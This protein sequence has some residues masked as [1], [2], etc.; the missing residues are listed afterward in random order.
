MKV[1]FITRSTLQTVPGGDTIQIVQT[2]RHLRMLGVEADILSA[3]AAIPYAQ[4]DLLHL[5]NITRPAD[6]LIHAQRCNIPYVI[7]PILIDYSEYDRHYRKGF[8][9]WLLRTG[10]PSFNEY[11]KTTARWLL[12][13]DKLVS[14]TYLWKGQRRSMQ[15]ILQGASAVLPNSVAEQKAIQATFSTPAIFTT[16]PNGIDTSLF[17]NNSPVDRDKNSV[18]CVA[19]IEGI[20]NQLHLIRALNDTSFQLKLIGAAAPGQ[21]KYYE[22]CRKE[23]A[24]NVTFMEHI[25]Q[26]ALLEYYRSAA[27]HVLPS[28]F[29][30]CGLSS[31]EAGAMG[32]TIVVT[33]KGYT[34]DYF[35][36]NAFYADPASPASIHDAIAQAALAPSNSELAKKISSDFTWQRAASVTFNVYQKIISG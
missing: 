26:E 14:R 31:L 34:R 7:S 4:Y 16:V 5:F 10:S 19:R 29:E 17:S 32:C 33:A 8:S 12:G 6:L 22:Q 28:W 23:A 1:G 9:G 15:A 24:S 13:H 25:P 20:K 2:V 3:D 11:I 36:N 35:G 30:T 27:V 21:R 18:I